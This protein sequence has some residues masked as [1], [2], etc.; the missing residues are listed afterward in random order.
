MKFLILA[1]AL[2][3]GASAHEMNR[4]GKLLL[5][6]STTS[7]TMSTTTSVLSTST[8]CFAVSANVVTATCRRRKRSVLEDPVSDNVDEIEVSRVSRDVSETVEDNV[9][10]GLEKG[11]KRDAKFF[12]YYMTTTSTSISTSTSSSFTATVS[13]TLTG[14]TP[15]GVFTVCG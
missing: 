2:V 9:D 11:A 13:V 12:W 8:T 1:S 3:L 10:S 14:C 5:V 4:E 15:G 6:T 7:V